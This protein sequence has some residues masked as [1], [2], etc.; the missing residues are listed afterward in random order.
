MQ[1]EI[2]EMGRTSLSVAL[3]PQS[4]SLLFEHSSAHQWRL[5]RMFNAVAHQRTCRALA[6][7]T[8]TTDEFGASHAL[9]KTVIEGSKAASASS[10]SASSA[11]ASSASASAS[12]S[13][14]AATL[15][16]EMRAVYAQAA[17]VA[18]NSPQMSAVLGALE[19]YHKTVDYAAAG[20]RDGGG[21][22]R[23]SL[24]QGPPGTGKSTASVA[25]LKLAAMSSESPLLA[26]ADS[27]AACDNLLEGMLSQGVNAVRIGR[28]GRAA[29]H[30]WAS[31]V[32]AQLESLPEHAELEEQRQQLRMLRVFAA[33]Q[34]GAARRETEQVLRDGW[35]R[36]RKD[37]QMLIRRLLEQAEVVV[38]TLVGC[39]SPAMLGMRFPMVVVDECTQAT[40]P[41][42]LI[43]LARA[44]ASVV[45]VGDQRQLAPTVISKEAAQS[46]LMRSLF[47]RLALAAP[48]VGTIDFSLLTIQ[49]RMHP[50]LRR[51]P[52][53]AFYSGQLTD[54]VDAS[55]RQPP[56]AFPGRMVVD[57]DSEAEHASGECKDESG[58]STVIASK[59]GLQG[60]EP[61][62]SKPASKPASKPEQVIGVRSPSSTCRTAARRAAGTASASSTGERR[63]PSRRSPSQC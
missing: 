63:P 8:S 37:E 53:D 3:E 4:S 35:R 38:S 30:L 51:F 48:G 2:V 29:A 56:E 45:L 59:A 54:G 58:T 10:A 9:R 22:H 44:M 1:C 15:T 27:N 5:D 57:A 25:L 31:T 26:C 33:E 6:E 32:E 61:H 17:G 11:S 41:R 46:G 52:S 20:H 47:E 43:A 60:A 39:G 49:Y 21:A 28:P 24:I 42:T 16:A 55:Q 23:I 12:A 40:E 14:P 50:L 18:L 34:V 13:A 7:W 36:V 19:G 62:P